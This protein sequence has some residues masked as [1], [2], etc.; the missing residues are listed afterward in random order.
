MSAAAAEHVDPAE[1][2][3]LKR[4]VE[5]LQKQ[6]AEHGRK[7]SA[8]KQSAK[9]KKA[10][11][12]KKIADEKDPLAALRD[13]DEPEEKVDLKPKRLHI[14]GFFDVSLV[15]YFN[16]KSSPFSSL[17]LDD[18][19]F[20]INRLNLYVSSELTRD[21]RFLV[22]LRYTFA[23]VGQVQ[24]VEA[25]LLGQTYQR[26]DDTVSELLVPRPYRLNGLMIERAHFTYRFHDL[27][28]VR[29]GR[30]LTPFGI[31]NVDHASTVL[32]TARQPSVFNPFFMPLAQT[33]LVA[34]GR[35]FSGAF[36]FDYQ[37]TLSNGRGPVEAAYDLDD[38][39]GVGLR[40]KATYEGASLQASLGGY[41]Y[42]G[43][44]TDK[45]T[46]ID[47][48]LS[49]PTA[50][51]ITVRDVILSEGDEY[52]ATADLQLKYKG[53]L[54]QGELVSRRIEFSVHPPANAVAD[55]FPVQLPNTGL[56]EPN[57]VGMAFYAL[58]VYELPL[59]R[60]LGDIRV[61]P[62]VMYEWIRISDARG[63]VVSGLTWGINV[64]PLLWLTL[65]AEGVWLADS[66]PNTPRHDN[67]GV[68]FQSAINF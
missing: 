16:D 64:Q 67:Y 10:A 53:L 12:D 41:F 20:V 33:G 24:S 60:W 35:L 36:R 25:P 43:K 45:K 14:Y 21:L 30:Y 52:V 62:Y 37:A 19:S 17:L 66:L 29:V 49:G 3:A 46:Q 4:Q 22:E 31:W 2:E 39:L 34:F 54:L 15:R 23:P 63:L 32:I 61:R 28:Q 57:Q 51:G 65:K 18:L 6:M 47:I 44:T 38:N 56:K 68:I 1:F 9:D 11:G 7:K 42:Y 26:S 55:L 48:G 13:D 5:K 59:G 8:D 40:L 58:A 27:L 50:G